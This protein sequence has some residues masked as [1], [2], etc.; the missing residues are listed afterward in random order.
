MSVRFAVRPAQDAPAENAPSRNRCAGATVWSLGHPYSTG[1]GTP[2]LS[3]LSAG[4]GL[5][6]NGRRKIMTQT[7]WHIDAAHSNLQ[8]SVRHMVITKVRGAFRSYRG[9]LKLDENAVL[10]LASVDVSIDAASIDTGEPKRDEHLK[11]SDFLDVA[12]HPALRFQS[13][14]VAREGDRY[15]VTGDLTIRGVTRSVV[16][17]AEFQGRGNDPWGGQRAAFSAKTSIDRA[18]FGLTWNQA[19]EAGG[20]LVG[21]KI[22]IDLEVQA[23]KAAQA[24]RAPAREAASAPA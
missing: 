14:S 6:T 4:L 19:L 21:T 24:E 5:A 18:D 1:D 3:G 7:E 17:D 23:V 16:L 8:F 13:R 9:T 10:S 15:R 12:S 11:S 22:E 20:V 2:I